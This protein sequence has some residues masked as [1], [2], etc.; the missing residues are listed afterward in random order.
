MPVKTFVGFGF[1]PI[2]GGLFLYE[3]FASGNFTRLVVAEVMQDL[4]D[5]LRRNG[6]KY[7]VNIATKSGVE[8]K[9]VKGVEVYNP[10]V[11]NEAGMLIEAAAEASE[12]ATAL[13]SVAFYERGEPTVAA[14]LARAFI[15]KIENPSLPSCVIYTGENHNHAAEIL[16]KAVLLRMP[17][18]QRDELKKRV[19]FLNTVIGK[20]SG[21]VTDPERINSE[22][23]A[24]LVRGWN[25]A[26][27]VEEFNK[28]LI[29]RIH[30]PDFKRGI[31]VFIEK[32]NLLPFEEAKLYGHNAVHALIGYLAHKK[33]YKLMSEVA[34]D[35]ELINM[36]REAF[37]QESG[38]AL[39]KKNGGIDLLF[40]EEGYKI[41][42]EDLLERMMNPFLKDQV[43]RVIRDP[44]RKLGWDDRLIG[45]MRIALDAGIKPV[46]FAKGAAAALSV[47]KNEMNFKSDEEIFSSLWPEPDIPPGRKEEIKQLIKEA[48]KSEMLQNETYEK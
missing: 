26:Y 36:A 19:E 33:N 22:N 10:S 18:H 45:T 2:Q 28:I 23:L 32:D 12:I 4:V 38:T 1:G 5:A 35:K 37:L 11:L 30:L 25:K 27:L 13:P 9:L 46:R 15:K 31:E 44:I 8:N 17:S 34:Q 39:I 47:L 41:Y 6:N 7:S 29:S 21:V 14:I 48:V 40:T 3:A 20:M 42:A 16:E 43:A 24:P